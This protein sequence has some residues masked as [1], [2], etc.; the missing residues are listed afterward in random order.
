MESQHIPVLVE[1]VMMLLRCEPGQIFVDATLGGGG[2]TLEIL[3]RTAPDGI[4]IGIDWDEEAISEATRALMPFGERAKIF[5]QSFVDLPGPLR[6]AK[7]EQ[8]DGI[9]LDLGLSSLH[10]ERAQRGFSLKVEQPLDMRM[11][12]RRDLTAADLVN[13]L[14]AQELEQTLLEYGEE[15]WARRIAKAIVVERQRSPIRT[16]QV[17]R[18]VV[19][20]AIPGRFHTRK[21]DP[22]TRT[23]QALRI[24]VNDELGN[25]RKVLEASWRFLKS[26]GRMCVI[27]FHSLEDRVVKEGFRKLEKE[28]KDGVGSG[29]VMRIITPKPV[30]PSEEERKRNPRSRSAKLRCAERV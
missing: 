15:R 26:G 12:D 1:E 24:R 23:F 4:V 2:H 18:K 25:L 21:I 20:R 3:R 14:S 13:S 30:T 22:S 7:V 19:L 11:D 16:T 27:S 10:L 17:L 6:A 29:G 28:G 8:V 5:R 9:L